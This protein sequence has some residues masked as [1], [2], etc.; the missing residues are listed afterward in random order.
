MW[1]LVELLHR[2]RLERPKPSRPLQSVARIS[3]R[4]SRGRARLDLFNAWE[5]LLLRPANK[6]RSASA[7]A[8][9]FHLTR[10]KPDVPLKW[11]KP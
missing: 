2:A 5:P 11:I 10:A 4:A 8:V 3:K 9:R 6:S 1:M 7:F